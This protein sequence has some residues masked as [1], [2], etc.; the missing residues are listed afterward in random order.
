[1]NV[2]L[3][4]CYQEKNASDAFLITNTQYTRRHGYVS[5]LGARC[6]TLKKSCPMR[7]KTDTEKLMTIHQL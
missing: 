6:N 1:M 3:M 7:I 5:L 4:Q 2:K